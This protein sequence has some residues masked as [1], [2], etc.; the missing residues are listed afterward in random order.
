MVIRLPLHPPLEDLTGC[1]GLGGWVGGWVVG[2][3]GGGLI[4]LPFVMGSKVE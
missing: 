4:E 2:G 3:E 1:V